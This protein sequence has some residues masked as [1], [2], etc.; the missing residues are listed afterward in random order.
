MTIVLPQ[1]FGTLT[2]VALLDVCKTPPFAVVPEC[3]GTSAELLTDRDVHAATRVHDA[4]ARIVQTDCGV[5][6]RQRCLTRWTNSDDAPAPEFR[7]GPETRLGRQRC[8]VARPSI[9]AAIG[10]DRAMLDPP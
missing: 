1:P 3:C 6:D 4:V 9:A 7:Y 2:P 10:A 8:C 5:E